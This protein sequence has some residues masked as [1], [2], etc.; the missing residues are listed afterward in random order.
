M[1][2]QFI[3]IIFL[4]SIGS[5]I[6]LVSNAPVSL[7]DPIKTKRKEHCPRTESPAS[8]HH[9]PP[10]PTH[11]GVVL[12]PILLM[13]SGEQRANPAYQVVNHQYQHPKHQADRDQ[14]HRRDHQHHL[15][16]RG[17]LASPHRP[18]RVPPHIRCVLSLQLLN[19]LGRWACCGGVGLEERLLVLQRGAAFRGDADGVFAGSVGSG[20]AIEFGRHCRNHNHNPN[21]KRRSKKNKPWQIDKGPVDDDFA[22]RPRTREGQ[23][24]S[25][26]PLIK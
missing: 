6:Y 13:R 4:E 20:E 21:P 18:V 9:L 3:V 12:L 23:L 15:L 26:D 8:D 17:D 1:K 24:R 25:S 19:A 2:N 7:F 11:M 14:R 22:G 5:S 16:R 10:P